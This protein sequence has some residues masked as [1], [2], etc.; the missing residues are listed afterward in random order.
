MAKQRNPA[1]EAK[2]LGEELERQARA[3]NK[4]AREAALAELAYQGATDAQLALA[5]S[6]DQTL[7]RMEKEKKALEDAKTARERWDQSVRAGIASA[8]RVAGAV[9][10]IVARQASG[11][12][13][14][15]G[16][17]VQSIAST[18]ALIP[19]LAGAAASAITGVLGAAVT[20]IYARTERLNQAVNQAMNSVI[21]GSLGADQALARIRI[22][23]FASEFQRVTTL[24]QN[25]RTGTFTIRQQSE[26]EIR[27]QLPADM[28][29]AAE[30]AE[31]AA[32]SLRAALEDPTVRRNLEVL[33]TRGT[34]Q[35]IRDIGRTAE[36]QREVSFER[37]RAMNLGASTE[38]AERLGQAYQLV[39]RHAANTRQID[40][41]TG[42][43]E[44]FEA[45]FRRSR[46]VMNDV[47]NS[48]QRLNMLSMQAASNERIAQQNRQD[49]INIRAQQAE[50]GTL[51]RQAVTG[52]LL[53]SHD[54]ERVELQE[55]RN[56]GTVTEI[57]YRIRL[58]Q[59]AE[60]EAS[61]LAR[62]NT[63]DV[64][65]RVTNNLRPL[66]R[67]FLERQRLEQLRPEL[68]KRG[69]VGQEILQRETA[70]LAQDII[71]AAG[72]LYRLPQVFEFGSAATASAISRAEREQRAGDPMTQL[73]AAIAALQEQARVQSDYQA[74]MVAALE[75]IQAAGGLPP[76]IFGPG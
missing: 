45:A 25:R 73:P 50:S 42:R 16:E 67:S 22:D 61:E 60:N 4:T 32:D 65:R 69:P 8:G 1:D 58:A 43:M 57:A 55:Q 9:G 23:A 38:E 41:A 54:R 6:F 62:R 76:G 48:Y 21:Q 40:P 15:T 75:T 46:A 72:D 66:E 36:Q 39:A 29:Q 63:E 19:G 2:E 10:G 70:R 49:E 52:E 28:R 3:F 71:A 56:R 37:V 27:A 24:A 18:T 47:I 68:L 13:V 64:N 14:S 33:R 34:Q 30:F 26:E 35:D 7:T 20:A 74:Q 53:V 12:V 5:R 44:S 59:I 11:N 51:R 17:A 31:R